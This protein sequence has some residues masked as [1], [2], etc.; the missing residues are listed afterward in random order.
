MQLGTEFPYGVLRAGKT[1][2]RLTPDGSQGNLVPLGDAL[3]GIL[4]P[5]DTLNRVII[6]GHE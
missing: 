6:S 4:D 5:S 3:K 2:F 1:E